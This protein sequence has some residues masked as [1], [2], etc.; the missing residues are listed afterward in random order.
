ME[1]N[2]PH[3]RLFRLGLT[4]HAVRRHPLPVCGSLETYGT[5][6]MWDILFYFILKRV[7]R[8]SKV[9]RRPAKTSFQVRLKAGGLEE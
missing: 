7:L 5:A 3:V 8:R 2:Q 4:D 6:G 9:L 1:G